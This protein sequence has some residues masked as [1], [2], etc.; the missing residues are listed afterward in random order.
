M[1]RA[2]D[3]VALDLMRAIKTRFDPLGL[4]NPGKLLPEPPAAA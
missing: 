4:L 3:P 2:L 1:P